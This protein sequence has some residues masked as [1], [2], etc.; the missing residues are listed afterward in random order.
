M[1]LTNYSVNK[2]SHRYVRLGFYFILFYLKIIIKIDVMIL[3][4]KILEINGQCQ[5]CYVY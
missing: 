2:R 4:L 1:H 5:L 3:I